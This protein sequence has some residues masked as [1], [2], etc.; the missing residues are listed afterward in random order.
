MRK[1]VASVGQD[2]IAFHHAGEQKDFEVA[3]QRLRVF[4]RMLVR[5][6]DPRILDRRRQQNRESLVAA[7]ESRWLQR[8]PGPDDYDGALGV[9]PGRCNT[10]QTAARDTRAFG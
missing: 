3:E 2:P 9:T 4:E 1:A 5:R 8:H 7:H 6:H 10:P